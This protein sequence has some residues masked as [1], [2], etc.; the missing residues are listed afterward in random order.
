[1]HL[2]DADRLEEV[3][4]AYRSKLEETRPKELYKWEAALQFRK[5]WKP[6]SP[7]FAEM[8]ERALS[9]SGNLLAGSM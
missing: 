6:D 3:L 8:L 4:V 2:F 5:E 9:K 1:M 7:D